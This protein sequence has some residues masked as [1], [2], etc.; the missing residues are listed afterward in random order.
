MATRR[1]ASGV[2]AVL[3]VL[4]RTVRSG[5]RTRDRCHADQGAHRR[6]AESTIKNL[7]QIEQGRPVLEQPQTARPRADLR[8]GDVSYSGAETTGPEAPDDA[9]AQTQPVVYLSSYRVAR[10]IERATTGELAPMGQREPAP[11]I[12]AVRRRDPSYCAPSLPE[13]VATVG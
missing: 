8:D 3:H 2:V 5:C 12:T 1:V 11:R 4:P 9:G 6:I 13:K 7:M 10:T